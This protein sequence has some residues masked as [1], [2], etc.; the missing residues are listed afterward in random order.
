LRTITW[1]TFQRSLLAALVPIS[2]NGT[3]KLDFGL[4]L[5]DDKSG[6]DIVDDLT[7]STRTSRLRFSE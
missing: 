1:F 3:K 6:V 5:V 2:K 4:A 7:A